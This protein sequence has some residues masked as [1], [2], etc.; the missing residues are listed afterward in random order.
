MAQASATRWDNGSRMQ[1]YFSAGGYARLWAL[2]S[3]FGSRHRFEVLR[4]I[5][6]GLAQDW[7]MACRS[8]GA[9][10]L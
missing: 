2:V 8:A 3:G 10:P 6:F 4:K 1:I 7:T 5:A 9:R